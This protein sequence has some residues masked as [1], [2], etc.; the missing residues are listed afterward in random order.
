MKSEHLL[1]VA[2]TT[3]LL[4]APLLGHAAADASAWRLGLEA[5]IGYDSNAYLA[6]GVSYIDH[7]ATGA[8]LVDPATHSGS[9]IPL[10]LKAAYV[11][12][13][14]R[15]LR[16]VGAYDFDAS[17]YPGSATENANR[18]DH[19]LKVGTEYTIAKRG[20][21]EDVVQVTPFLRSHD[22]TYFNRDTGDAMVSAAGTD[23]SE[24]YSYTATGIE[25]RYE[26]ETS[27]LPY[28]L[29][30]LLTD[31]NYEEPPS[32]AF[33]SYD[34]TYF[35]VGGDL[36][37]PVSKR[38]K[39]ILSLDHFTRDYDEWRARDLSGTK[40]AGTARKYTYNKLGASVRGAIG[41]Q[42][43]VYLDYAMLDR[44]DNHLGYHDYTQDGYG[45]RVIYKPDR[46]LRV[47]G[48]LAWWDRDYDH[49]FAF[50]DPTQPGMTYDS[51]QLKLRADYALAKPYG[52]WAEV[53]TRDVDST[54]TR[55]DYERTQLMV[56]WRW[57]T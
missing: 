2:F 23:L 43:V 27:K 40:V 29:E 56:G 10:E 42:W 28:S 8:P 50:D 7:A 20:R 13:D 9:F 4:G 53:E 51:Q 49:A 35:R 14:H 36:N 12:N 33:D 21:R 15:K 30:L 17:L 24:R 11:D 44:E 41:R 31:L 54:D 38:S 5:G 52:V 32:A 1:P 47:R 25:A 37:L 45:L 48:K 46:R 34:H 26:S 16:W 57:E 39:V 3:A 55:Y 19:E 6:P 22:K 18:Y